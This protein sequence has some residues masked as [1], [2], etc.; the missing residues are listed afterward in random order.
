MSGRAP[1][2]VVT[3]AA[4]GIGAAT[5]EKLVGAGYSVALWDIDEAGSAALAARLTDQG[6]RTVPVLTDVAD[7]S[8]VR[9]ALAVTRE[10]LGTPTA[11]VCAAGIMAPQPFLKLSAETWNRT[12]RVNLTGTFTVLQ[13]C[14]TAMTEDGLPGA[15]AAVASVAARG[16]RADAA[17]YAASKAGVV[18][19]VRSAAVALAPHGI[20]VNAVCPGVVDTPMT[21]HNTQERA[22]LQ[23]IPEEQITKTLVTKVALGRM[24]AA[25]E[26]AAVVAR[27]LG[28]EFGY[29]TGQ[30]LNVCGG[31][32]F[33]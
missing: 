12:L 11:V 30:A 16:P 32:E 25:H 31:L 18:S 19:V 15:M 4:A 29:V 14:A 5:A 26:I 33:D 1:V 22:K 9:E 2:A 24:A 10:A 27:L 17:D 23:G 8:S 3:G 7:P 21:A 20:R 6:G 13:A 28:D